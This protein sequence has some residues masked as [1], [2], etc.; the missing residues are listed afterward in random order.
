MQCVRHDLLEFK[1][2]PKLLGCIT[3]LI[4]SVMLAEA[5]SH[6]ASPLYAVTSSVRI[7]APPERVWPNLIKFPDLPPPYEPLFKVGVAYPI[8]AHID[9]HGVGAVRHCVFST[10][11]FVEPITVWDA[12]RLLRFGVRAQAQPM[13]ELSPYQDLHPP[14]LDKCLISKQG[15]FVLTP[16]KDGTTL[17]SGTTWYQNNMGPG[18]YWRIWSD[19]IIHTI[20]MRV[21]DHV[22]NLSENRALTALPQSDQ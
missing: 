16:L 19:S 1:Q 20:H 5:A 11:T 12:P 3:I 22:K 6:P 13:Y 8:K 18:P 9:G 14:H 15:Q 10:G 21:L 7:N 2:T 17:L 4:P